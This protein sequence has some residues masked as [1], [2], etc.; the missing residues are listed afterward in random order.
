M[1]QTPAARQADAAGAA[2]SGQVVRTGVDALRDALSGNA[3]AFADWRRQPVTRRVLGALQSMLLHPPAGLSGDDAL[4]QYGVTQ[5]LAL[6]VSLMADPS[7]LW[8]GVFGPGTAGAAPEPLEMTFDTPLD[9]A[10][11]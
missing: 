8:P 2:P 5:G 11:K 10:F 4:V 9:E 7:T 1:T 6:A 3:S